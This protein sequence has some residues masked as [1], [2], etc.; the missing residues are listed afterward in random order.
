MSASHVEEFWQQLSIKSK[1]SASTHKQPLSALLF[2]YR[3][4]LK[5]YLPWLE[6]VSRLT[7]SKRLPVVLTRQEVA[8]AFSNL[9]GVHLLIAKLLYCTGMRIMEA[10]RLHRS[11]PQ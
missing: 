5:Q 4:V 9:E 10:L 2:L 7:T 8:S 3:E 6:E 1:V 11:K